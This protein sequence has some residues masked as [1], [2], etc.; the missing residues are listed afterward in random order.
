MAL[1]ALVV[2]VGAAAPALAQSGP[3]SSISDAT[4]VPGQTV[5][6]RAGGLT[7]GGI[8]LIDYIP[9]GVRLA[10]VH[11]GVDGSFVKDVQIPTD[12][13][14]GRKQI[15]VTAI[16]AD[17]TY[18]YLPND[19]TVKGPDAA[20]RV[21]DTTL[22]PRQQLR[23]SGTRFLRGGSVY[24]LL[25][26][27][28]V[29]L[30]TATAS[31]DGTFALDVR[32]PSKLLNGRHGLVITGLTASGGYAYLQRLVMVI[33]GLGDLPGGG[34]ADPFTHTA[35][36]ATS[37]TSTLPTATGVRTPV[38]A[39]RHTGLVLLAL[40]LLS[41]TGLAILGVT[42]LWTPAGRTWR[43]RRRERRSGRPS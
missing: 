9:D 3:S 10:T 16:A 39:S 24:A 14:D 37:T 18:A 32:M 13:P 12:S 8:A 2:V 5:T 19:L 6:V 17:G 27:E 43:R 42:W 23:I 30:G 34:T 28:Q 4:T 36:R 7:P 40:L 35:T 26:P 21:S 41:G 38:A 33:G 31:A 11:A 20:I 22:R 1:L 15:V 25:F 29:L